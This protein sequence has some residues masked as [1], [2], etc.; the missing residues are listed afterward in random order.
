MTDETTTVRQDGQRF[1]I[2]VDGVD[3][4]FTEFRDHEGERV[5]LHTEL[6]DAFS[7]RGLSGILVQQALDATRDAGLRIVPVCPL[8]A[9]WLT[10][11]HDFDDIVD[12]PA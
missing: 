12:L 7:G 9:H 5:F 4:G 6:D 1:V 8:I 3:A 2:S 10:K 11:H